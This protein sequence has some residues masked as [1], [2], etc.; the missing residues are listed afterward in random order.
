MKLE[1]ANRRIDN[2]CNPA[3][4]MCSAVLV[5]VM[6]RALSPFKPLLQHVLT[7]AQLA[8]A[9]LLLAPEATFLPIFTLIQHDII[10]HN[11]VDALCHDR[12]A[13]RSQSD[14]VS[15]V[16]F[17]GISHI[18]TLL[19]RAFHFDAIRTAHHRAGRAWDSE[20]FLLFSSAGMFASAPVFG[21]LSIVLILLFF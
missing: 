14:E 4:R 21:A 9:V 11:I 8:V 13:D 18:A 1:T 12:A 17:F 6:T 7:L 2:S 20:L 19:S 3:F 15:N 16:A 10:V 5:D